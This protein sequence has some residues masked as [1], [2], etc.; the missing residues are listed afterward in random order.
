MS[1]WG[2]P[3]SGREQA[4]ET[5]IDMEPHGSFYRAAKTLVSKDWYCC[6]RNNYASGKRGGVVLDDFQTQY[7]VFFFK[8]T[9]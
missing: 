3:P 9:K 6:P 5:L 4:I 7:E 2:E 8:N 1:V